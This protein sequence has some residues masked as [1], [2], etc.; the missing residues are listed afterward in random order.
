M[1]N[2]GYIDNVYFERTSGRLSETT[3]LETK[4]PSCN[5]R[6]AKNRVNHHVVL[7]YKYDHNKTNDQPLSASNIYHDKCY[8][9]PEFENAP[10]NGEL[11]LFLPE[12]AYYCG[13]M[14]NDL[15]LNSPPY[16]LWD[17]HGVSD[18]N[19]LRVV[20]SDGLWGAAFYDGHGTLDIAFK[21]SDEAVRYAIERSKEESRSNL[22]SVMKLFKNM[23]D[24]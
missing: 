7:E 2:N 6:F 18:N 13:G 16:I 1:T 19:P 22:E 5:K 23:V 11:I 12:D 10:K 24:K 15:I 20:F 3:R 8:V 4:C 9:F 14:T 17:V 21:T